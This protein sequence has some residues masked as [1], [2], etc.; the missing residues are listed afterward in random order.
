MHSQYGEVGTKI[1]AGDWS[2]ETQ[3][4]LHEG[5]AAFASDFGYDLDQE[6]HP[7]EEAK[8]A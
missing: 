3:K 8:A 1:A 6:G 5:V 7:L 2:E 4:S